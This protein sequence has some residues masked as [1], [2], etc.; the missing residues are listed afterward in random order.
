MS[1]ITDLIHFA[2]QTL[3]ILE[4]DH[5][6]SSDTTD[7]IADLAH[8][9]QLSRTSPE[10]RLFEAIS[11]PVP[12]SAFIATASSPVTVY[13]CKANLQTG[14]TVRIYQGSRSVDTHSVS[15]AG[16]AEMTHDASTGRA[17]AS[18]ARCVL[19]I[20]DGII[21]PAPPITDP[22]ARAPRASAKTKK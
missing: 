17:K 12:R 8:R 7:D 14:N 20:T 15:I 21:I 18:G 22:C 16:H 6:W 11:V 4:Q 10:T 9:L 2:R 19:T 13:Y 5:E 3:Q 1:T